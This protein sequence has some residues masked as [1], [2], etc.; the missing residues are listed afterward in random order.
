MLQPVVTR[1]PNIQPL[2]QTRHLVRAK[3]EYFTDVQ[4]WPLLDKL[5]P[6]RWFENF[7]DAENEFAT[8]LL[9]S[10]LY[11]SEPIT[12]QLFESAFQALSIH[13]SFTRGTFSHAQDQWRAFLDN[14]LVTSVTGETPN[15]TDSGFAFLRM[16][17]QRL[18][19]DQ[20]RIGSPIEIANALLNSS[21]RPVV[22][23]DDFVGSGRQCVATWKRSMSLSKGRKDSFENLAT[24]LGVSFYYCPLISTERGFQ[25]V[26]TEC[27][28]LNLSCPHILSDRYN[29]LAADSLIW[30][31]HLRPNAKTFLQSA[32]ERAGIPETDWRGYDDLGLSLAFA[33]SVP[34]ATLPLFYW[35]ENGWRPLIRRT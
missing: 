32:S 30:P 27:P 34:D 10:F 29:A 6:G 13:P 31:D 8:H 24:K 4:L 33:H 20:G 25:R 16:A 7:S 3:C 11:F 12:E 26:R 22:F 1:F 35:K 18:E 17:R 5:D 19:I 15:S 2:E 14:V 23:V 21:P 28:G 9:G